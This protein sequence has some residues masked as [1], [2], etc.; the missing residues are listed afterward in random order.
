MHHLHPDSAVEINMIHFSN[1]QM[2]QTCMAAVW[3]LNQIDATLGG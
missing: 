3:K 1:T 2:I